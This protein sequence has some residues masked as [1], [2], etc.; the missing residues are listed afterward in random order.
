M[1]STSLA[2]ILVLLLAGA[3]AAAPIDFRNAPFSGATERWQDIVLR[4]SVSPSLPA[5]AEHACI[6]TQ[7]MGLGCVTAMKPMK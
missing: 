4:S 6:R 7:P 1:K 3:A 2:V 5:Q